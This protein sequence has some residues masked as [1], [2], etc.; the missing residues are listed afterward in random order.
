MGAG[1]IRWLGMRKPTL[2]AIAI[3]LSACGYGEAG[4]AGSPIV[5]TTTTTT[6]TMQPSTTIVAEDAAPASSTTS[7]AA[8]DV[9]VEGTSDEVPDTLAKADVPETTSTTT[10]ST[11]TTTTTTSTT[12]TTAAPVIPDAVDVFCAAMREVAD[13]NPHQAAIETDAVAYASYIEWEIAQLE[14]AVVPAEINADFAA[15]LEAE[16]RTLTWI[17]ANSADLADVRALGSNLAST[18]G[19]TDLSAGVSRYLGFLRAECPGF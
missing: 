5:E 7:T 16:R 8:P 2:L 10:T 19:I 11:T 6:T 14:R 18:L 17:R 3:L 15:Y 1:A 12:T 13:N 4:E 9:A